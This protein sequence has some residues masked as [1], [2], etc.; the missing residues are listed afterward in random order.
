[1]GTLL[2]LLAAL[3]SD[4]FIQIAN[5][6][7]FSDSIPTNTEY[8]DSTVPTAPTTALTSATASSQTVV[9][10]AT[11][12]PGSTERQSTAPQITTGGGVGSGIT[13]GGGVG[14]GIDPTPEGNELINDELKD[15][16]EEAKG[17][18][19]DAG[20][21]VLD[22]V[23]TQVNLLVQGFR[24][25]VSEALP[26]DEA[27]SLIQ[28]VE[29]TAARIQSQLQAAITGVIAEFEA[30]LNAYLSLLGSFLVETTSDSA[31]TNTPGNLLLLERRSSNLPEDLQQKIDELTALAQARAN[32]LREAVQQQ[33]DDLKAAMDS[34]PQAVRTAVDELTDQ[35]KEAAE[36]TT[37][38]LTELFND[39]INQLVE[40]AEE[41]I[42]EFQCT[43]PHVS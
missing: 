29:T 4:G 21:T 5:G 18:V 35:L 36:D 14:S 7:S 22:V 25:A 1:M 8:I 42:G 43:V 39:Q 26:S 41:N 10:P 17:T 19:T 32:D 16:V 37:N 40:A 2:A 31:P 13:T 3:F 9:I 33:I 34:Q 24:E 15:E 23:A 38:Q 30:L 6:E 20:N 11:T 12:A 28:G 27:E